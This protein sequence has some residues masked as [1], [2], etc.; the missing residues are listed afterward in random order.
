MKGFALGAWAGA[1]LMSR[2]L[3]QNPWRILT[4]NTLVAPAPFFSLFPSEQLFSRSSSALPVALGGHLELGLGLAMSFSRPHPPA[5]WAHPATTLAGFPLSLPGLFCFAG[6]VNAVVAQG[7][8]RTLYCT[9]LAHP[10]EVRNY[11]QQQF[12]LGSLGCIW[13]TKH[14]AA[15]SATHQD[16]GLWRELAAG[17]ASLPWHRWPP[18]VLLLFKIRCALAD[19]RGMSNAQERCRVGWRVWHVGDAEPC[20]PLVVRWLWFVVWVFCFVFFS[21]RLSCFSLSS[22]VMV[23]GQGGPAP[24]TAKKNTLS[25]W[26]L[27]AHVVSWQGLGVQHCMCVHGWEWMGRR[28]VQPSKWFKGKNKPNWKLQESLRSPWNSCF[29]SANQRV[30]RKRDISETCWS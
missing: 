28:I 12:V 9:A 30:G 18:S 10:A 15:T 22:C 6:N 2:H 16:Q 5:P 26:P 7:S 1:K 8:H 24:Y 27:N 3:G 25:S 13:D 11:K 4:W 19:A 17:L 21:G 20:L 29:P 14:N 23:S